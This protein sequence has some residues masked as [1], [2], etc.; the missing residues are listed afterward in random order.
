MRPTYRCYWVIHLISL[1]AAMSSTMTTIGNLGPG[2]VDDCSPSLIVPPPPAA[3]RFEDLGISPELLKGI[4]AQMTYEM[5]SDIQAVSLP[6]ILTPPYKHLIAQSKNGTGKTACFVVGM[7]SRVDPNL[8]ATQAICICPTRELAFQ[9]MDVLLKIGKFTGIT[10]ELG[11]PATQA[12]YL[13]VNKR[14]AVTAQV[15]IG[16]PG[17]INKWIAAKKLDTSKMK[18]LVFDEAD[19]MLE[20][21]PQFAK[22]LITRMQLISTGS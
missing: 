11:L 8:C 14:A 16:T 10:S 15:V 13:P 17:T 22:A 2:F 19:H 9:S 12:S 5:P 4:H 18:I 1:E 21:A 3:V 6:K 7:L 20:E